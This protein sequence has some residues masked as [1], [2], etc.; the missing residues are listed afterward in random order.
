MKKTI[1][2]FIILFCASCTT[3]TTVKDDS[4][5]GKVDAKEDSFLTEEVK[6]RSEVFRVLMKADAYTVAQKFNAESIGRAKDD[7]GDQYFMTEIANL[8][9]IDEVRHGIVGVW[10]YPDTGKLMQVRFLQS[11]YLRELD[12]MILDDIQRWTF[13]F[14]KKRIDPIKFNVHYKIV[15]EKKLSD[16]QIMDEV[17]QGIKERTGQ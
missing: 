6:N 8:N 9:K 2:L 3:T 11:T 4:K 1:A 10:L 5:P 16:E 17:R 14:P 13:E 12:T 7:S 15:L